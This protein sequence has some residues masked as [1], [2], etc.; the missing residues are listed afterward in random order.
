MLNI[1]QI[2]RIFVLEVIIT[3]DYSEILGDVGVFKNLVL[4]VLITITPWN[5][6]IIIRIRIR[7]F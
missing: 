1:C 3:I 2:F 5:K 6:A 4:V 7:E